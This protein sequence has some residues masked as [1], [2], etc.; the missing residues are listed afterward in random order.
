MKSLE[1]MMF[2]MI[3]AI[4][5]DA[6]FTYP[7]MLSS[8]DAIL[9]SV[10]EAVKH[11]GISF[12]TITLPEALKYL[13]F[14]LTAGYLLEERPK[15]HGRYSRLDQRPA[16]LHY[17][18]SRCFDEHGRAEDNV[19]H[20]SVFLLRQFYGCFK[21]FNID[22]DPAKVTAAVAGYISTEESLP[23][24]WPSTWDSDVPVWCS[25]DGH[26]LWGDALLSQDRHPDLFG[27]E[28][29]GDTISLAQWKQFRRLC[30]VIVTSLGPIDTWAI[31][32][33][34][35]PGVV[36]DAR[37]GS[38][39]YELRNWPKKLGAVFPPD[40]FGSHDLVDRTRSDREFPSKLIAVPKTQKA[41]RL[42]ASE[43]TA[44]QWIQGGIQRWLEDK[45]KSSFLSLSIDF[46]N[47][48][49]SANM[50]LEASKTGEFATVDLSEASDRLS[51][52]LVE[53]VFQSN[54]GL[55]DAF[56]ACRSR[57]VL[58]PSSLSGDGADRLLKLRKFAAM[59]SA[60]TFPVQT[61]V[62]TIICHFAL[63][64]VDGD[65]K[66]DLPS[67]RRRAHRIRVFGDDIIIDK[68]AYPRLV[69]VL[70]TLG[71][72]VNTAKSFHSGSFREACGMDAYGGSDVTP[73]YVRTQ[74]HPSIP[75]SLVSVVETSNNFYKKGLWRA[76]DYLLKTVGQDELPFI[77]VSNRDIGSV[78][79]FHFGAMDSLP[80]HRRYNRKLHRM[81]YR[82]LTLSQQ[83]KRKPG[84]GEASLLQ[85]FT[86]APPVDWWEDNLVPKWT[87][88]QAMKPK[89]RKQLRWAALY[90][91]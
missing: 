85:Y 63:M 17:L 40:W 52:R 47:Q 57:S 84:T 82:L 79:L 58:I 23:S 41:P 59:G 14:S 34:H 69:E 39:K 32:P 77:P 68:D 2:G 8:V 10:E 48:A 62:F 51:T 4:C 75:E 55:L 16:F 7:G 56:H 35:G 12:Y 50:A 70:T 66:C 67:L 60:L 11:R 90:S 81:E 43:P 25:R 71:L 28:Q 27:F 31:R 38:F 42:I 61:I 26:P 80:T 19:D 64:L 1:S 33:K 73:A 74:Y 89:L 91:D 21:K 72:K 65:M 18:W 44:H 15:Y 20:H 6:S 37:T 53:F 9:R 30:N 46:E 83:A 87:T 29:P 88:G 36:S 13:D 22:C 3:R 5:E 24:S 76:A 54:R 78:T 45:V 86:E 49:L